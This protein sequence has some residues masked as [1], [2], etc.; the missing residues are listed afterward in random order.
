MNRQTRRGFVQTVVVVG[1]GVA[2]GCGTSDPGTDAGTR[3]DTG[4]GGA[5]SGPFMCGMVNSTI[6]SNHGHVLTVPLADVTAAADRTYDITGAGGHAHNVTVTAA[7]FGML[8]AGM[9]VTT[10]STIGAA[11]GHMVTVTCARA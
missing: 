6:G 7:Q 9:T 8:Q 5:D 10:N 11:H 1:G 3:A 2:I 4:S